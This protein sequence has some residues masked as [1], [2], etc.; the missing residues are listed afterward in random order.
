MAPTPRVQKRESFHHRSICKILS[1]EGQKAKK[2]NRGR[3][4]GP[5]RGPS[6]SGRRC[7][8]PLATRRFD[9]PIACRPWFPGLEERQHRGP[10]PC[11]HAVVRMPPRASCGRLECWTEPDRQP[12]L[13]PAGRAMDGMTWTVSIQVLLP[14]S[15]IFPHGTVAVPEPEA[16][17]RQYPYVRARELSGLGSLLL[18]SPLG[19]VHRLSIRDGDGRRRLLS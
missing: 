11:L 15:S 4:R 14:P 7:P 16:S 8:V 19:S 1:R 2:E 17:A 3:G 6:P 18:C 5:R 10:A 12:A 9:P 13:G